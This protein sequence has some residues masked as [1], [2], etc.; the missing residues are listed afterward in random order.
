[1][2]IKYLPSDSYKYSQ[3]LYSSFNNNLISGISQGLSLYSPDQDIKLYKPLD[4]KPLDNINFDEV[5]DRLK[6]NENI[7][8]NT[9][10]SLSGALSGLFEGTGKGLN[11]FA[12]NFLGIDSAGLKTYIGLFLVFLLIYKKF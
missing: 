11:E 9:K 12:T 2:S 4:F 5:N 6:T 10:S 1:M 8:N 3:S 7:Y